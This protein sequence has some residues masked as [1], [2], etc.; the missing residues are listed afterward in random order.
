MQKFIVFVVLSLVAT[1]GIH[2]NASPVTDSS[3]AESGVTDV[4]DDVDDMDEL[5]QAV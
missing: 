1:C 2:T 5:G 4:T 3:I